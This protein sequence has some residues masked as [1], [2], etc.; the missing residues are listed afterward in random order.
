MWGTSRR[1]R[2]TAGCTAS[3][4]SSALRALRISTSQASI[5][6]PIGTPAQVGPAQTHAQA[7]A[8]NLGPHKVHAASAPPDG[9]APWHHP[10]DWA[11]APGPANAVARSMPGKGHVMQAV[12]GDRPALEALYLATGGEQWTY[13]KDNWMDPGSVCDWD[14][15]DG[16]DGLDTNDQC[17]EGTQQ[18]TVLSLGDNHLNGTLPEAMGQMTA[19]T[20]LYLQENQLSGP[21]PDA[22]GQMTALKYL[23]LDNNQLIGTLPEAFGRMTALIRLELQHNQLSGFILDQVFGH[24]DCLGTTCLGSLQLAYNNW[25]CP[26][27][28]NPWTDKAQTTCTD[29]DPS[30]PLI[31]LYNSTKGFGWLNPGFWASTASACSWQGV[32]CGDHSVVARLDLAANNL[33]GQLPDTIWASPTLAVGLT[34]LLL[35]GN[36][37]TGSLPGTVISMPVLQVLDLS[38]NELSSLVQKK[39]EKD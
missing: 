22:V 36:S 1:L 29:P 17:I 15:L 10:A 9:L 19:L 4:M 14:G 26:L 13:H 8:Q 34:A 30:T 16:V 20:Y 21:I 3:H 35:A 2:C 18:V 38:F 31:Q 11:P 7:Q 23:F 12:A 33:T 25:T 37:L 27:P 6:R 39:R 32:G 5:Y 24:N 28:E